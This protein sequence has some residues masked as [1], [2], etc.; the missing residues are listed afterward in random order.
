MSVNKPNHR[1]AL[2]DSHTIHSSRNSAYAPV[3]PELARFK[4][5][6]KEILEKLHNRY[7][8]GAR[9]KPF[10]A[11]KPWCE[12]IRFAEMYFWGRI[13]KKETTL[14]AERFKQLRQFAKALDRAHGL[15]IRAMHR[16]IGIDIFQAWCA[17]AKIFAADVISTGDLD[18]PVRAIEDIKKATEGLANL[19]TAAFKAAMANAV[20][21][22]GGRPALLPS[23][24]FHGLAR[25]YRESTG[26][27]PGRGAGPFADFAFEVIRALHPP[28]FEFEYD[29]VV[30]GII[31]AHRLHTPSMF[32]D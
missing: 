10:N 32:D 25:V 26:L 22:K 9:T 19:K 15:A 1:K 4:S 30:G 16:D 11:D 18:R 23:E 2:W 6:K 5:H 12:L 27:K 8:D 3:A 14:P 24:Y 29:S 20:P 17:E 31:D 28:D 7:Q 13:M 21:P